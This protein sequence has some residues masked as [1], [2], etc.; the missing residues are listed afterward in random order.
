MNKN[1]LIYQNFSFIPFGS[2][3][4]LFFTCFYYFTIVF[5][6]FFLVKL[7]YYYFFLELLLAVALFWLFLWL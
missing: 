7:S 6:N 4:F 5:I 3:L 1:C 2:E